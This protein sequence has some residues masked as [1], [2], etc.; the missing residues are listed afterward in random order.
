MII[1]NNE[2]IAEDGYILTNGEYYTSYAILGIYDALSN[3]REILLEEVPQD[4]Q[5]STEDSLFN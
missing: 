2:I 1:N 5:L 4:E 3:W